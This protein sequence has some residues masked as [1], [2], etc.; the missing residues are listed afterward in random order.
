MWLSVRGACIGALSAHA[1]ERMINPEPSF[2][3]DLVIYNLIV[4][5]LAGKLNW[6]DVQG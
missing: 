1:I 2:L 4:F 3:W 6:K 5:A